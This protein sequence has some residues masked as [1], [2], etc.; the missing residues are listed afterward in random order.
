MSRVR[1]SHHKGTVI[2]SGV[3][4]A[5]GQTESAKRSRRICGCSAT[6]FRFATRVWRPRSSQHPWRLDCYTGIVEKADPSL[7]SGRQ[8]FY[9]E[10][11]RQESRYGEDWGASPS[12]RGVDG[13]TA[14][15]RS[16]SSTNSKDSFRQMVTKATTRSAARRACTPAADSV[17]RV[18]LMDE[19]FAID[20][21]A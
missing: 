12:E 7:R 18:T 6:N 21:E 15:G 10:F 9:G 4:P 14:M 1:S 3:W 8:G 16:C 20:R 11:R 19:L 2:L 5:V 17:R 13:A